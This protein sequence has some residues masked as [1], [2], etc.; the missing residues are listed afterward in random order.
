[1]TRWGHW[2][3][4]KRAQ[5]HKAGIWEPTSDARTTLTPE[6]CFLPLRPEPRTPESHADGSW[7]DV[8]W[9]DLL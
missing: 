7:K 6:R 1:M 4:R 5:N 2:E 8:E 3:G 9:E